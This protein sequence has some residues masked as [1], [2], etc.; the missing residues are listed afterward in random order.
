V[1]VPSRCAPTILLACGMVG[2]LVAAAAASTSLP[3]REFFL[4]PASNRMLVLAHGGVDPASFKLRV[5]GEQWLVEQ[6]FH[7]RARSGEVVPLR[8]WTEDGT[9]VVVVEYRFQPGVSEPRLALRPMAPPPVRASTGDGG[10]A[11]AAAAERWTFAEAGDL[12]V[13]GSKS[14]AVASGNRRDLTVDQ[15]LRLNI[16]GQLTQDIFVRA[17]LTDDN[18]PVVPEG[19]TEQLQDIDQVLVELT[20]PTWRATLGDFVAIRRG[21]RFGDYRRKLQ[22]FTLAVEPGVGRGEAL[23]GSPRGRYRTVELRG[24]EANQG[25]YFLGSGAVGR[26]LFVVAGSERVVMNGQA[27]T[28]GADRDYVIDYV[29]GT[30]TFTYRRLVT[31]ET[32]ILVEFEEGEGE[33]GRTVVGAGG[34]A[35]F[36]V[37]AVPARV[38]VRVTREAD[39]PGR[40]RAGELSS[41]DEEILRQAG[42]DPLLAVAPG[43][44]AV[45]IGEG[46]YVRIEHTDGP[47]YE[48][49]EAGGD[50]QVTFFYSGPGL[51]DYRQSRLTETGRRIH[52]WVGMGQGSYRVGRQLPLPQAQSMVTMTAAA[53]DTVLA[54]VHAEWH[55]SSR[56]RNVISSRDDEDNSGQAAHVAARSGPQV[57][58]PGTLLARADW[59]WRDDRFA[60]FLVD[61]TVYQ[62][63]AWGL[64]ERAQRPGFLEAAVSELSTGLEW[65][66]RG[67]DHDLSLAA[68]LGRLDHGDALEA[69]RLGLRGR[70]RWRGA[71]GQHQRLAASSRDGRDPLD[72]TRRDDQH[73]LSWRL[74][75]VVPRAAWSSRRWQDDAPEAQV[76]GRAHGSRLEQLTAG[77]G[78]GPA[79]PWSWDLQFTRGLADSLRGEAWAGERDSRTWQGMLSTPRLGGVRATADGTVRQVRR[80]GGADET[81]RLGRLELAG[82]W[83]LL[84]SDWNLGYTVDNSRAEVLAR[85]VAFVGVNE[86]R[87][88]EFGNF[89]GDGRGDFE[90]LLA[91]TD[92]LV[93]T[94]AVRAD[95]TWRQDMQRFGRDR[96]WGAWTSETRVAVEG[97]SS[98]DEV[99]PLLRLARSAI[100]DPEHTVLGRFDLSEEL[101]L[102]RHLRAWDLRYRFDLAEVMDRQYAQGR[103]D[104]LRREHTTTVTWNPGATVSL[105]LRGGVEDDR[106][107]T[108]AELNPTQLDYTVT[109]RRGEGEASWRPAAGSRVALAIEYLT[110]DDT[111]SRVSQ[112]EVALRPSVRWRLAQRWSAQADVRLA[113]VNS[114]EPPGSRR[115]Y[116]F[117][118]PGTNVE[119][120][121][122]IGW[123]PSRYLNVAVAWFARRPGGRMWQHDLRL[124]STAR[125]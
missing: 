60:P 88:D 3:E 124:E 113:D 46:D 63:E 8:A 65:L 100:F 56:D 33:F 83:P 99:G 68:D 76:P 2:A 24:Q 16:S 122:R 37:G 45:P 105:R 13:R 80:P 49:V 9:V 109:T 30:I 101:T 40:L 73:A 90:L 11:D 52:E 1:S 96:L 103:Q 32:L 95:L 59:S 75:P 106:R 12:D 102:L 114:D 23:F 72:I 29:R 27:L 111:I 70:W 71:E 97:R 112:R 20:A 69:E 119:A 15:T 42:D 22:G 98:A 55:L 36:V 79:V 47:R 107:S 50:W 86:G 58:G 17:M 104:R 78:S 118:P 116:F 87:Y 31:A 115:P 89:V 64:G 54:G 53:G 120:A 44:V 51:G 18:L 74:G 48:F 61:R 77:L 121:T 7:L 93:A 110:R 92:S 39:D 62:Y 5:G 10:V 38:G 125:F 26:N 25:P 82:R 85:Q 21:T 14:V 117:L 66:T 94:T 123:D 43:A 67:A 28:R 35:Q 57:L 6:D 19:N 84:G 91:G 108:D 41:D 4:V 81:T 34:G